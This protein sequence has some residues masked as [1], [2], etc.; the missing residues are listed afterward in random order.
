MMAVFFF[1]TL[2]IF[3]EDFGR[4]DKTVRSETVEV[5]IF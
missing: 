1:V 2:P 4:A 5:V 3:A